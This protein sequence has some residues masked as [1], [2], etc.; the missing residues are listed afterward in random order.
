MR[1]LQR[2]RL[3]LAL[4]LGLL[5]GQG[6]S[7]RLARAVEEQ[8]PNTLFSACLEES[9]T[10]KSAALRLACDVA[11]KALGFARGF[12]RDCTADDSG[13]SQNDPDLGRC[14]EPATE[15]FCRGVGP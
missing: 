5:M 3:V 15:H 1:C 10:E 4:A 9:D 13:C 6:V 2:R 7:G 11:A 8:P 12:L 14:V